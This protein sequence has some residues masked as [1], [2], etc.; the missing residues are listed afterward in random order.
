MHAHRVEVFDG[1]HDN[2]VALLVAHDF[3][4]EF[5]PAEERFF[6]KDF[7]VERCIKTTVYD[8]LEFFGVVGDTAAS[9]AERKAWT[10]N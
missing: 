7:V 4:L 9:A 1:A 5:F 10:N 8:G 6:D 3:H 2:G